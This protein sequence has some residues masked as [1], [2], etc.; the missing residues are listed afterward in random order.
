MS[1]KISWGRMV[2]TLGYGTTLKFVCFLCVKLSDLTDDVKLHVV[3]NFSSCQIVFKSK[4][5]SSQIIFNSKISS[6]TKFFSKLKFVF[7][8]KNSKSKIFLVKKSSSIFFLLEIIFYF[9]EILNFRKLSS[10]KNI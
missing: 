5:F 2:K 1:T 10:E 8:K 6:K 9:E 4:I 7:K 3:P